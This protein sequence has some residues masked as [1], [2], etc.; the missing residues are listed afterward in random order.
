MFLLVILEWLT[1]MLDCLTME[2]TSVNK[3]QELQFRV[4]VTTSIWKQ[5]KLTTTPMK[6]K[7]L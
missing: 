5:F 3:E 2:T 1:K 7:A 6:V 4:N